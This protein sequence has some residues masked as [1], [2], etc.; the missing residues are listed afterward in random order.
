MKSKLVIGVT[1]LFLSGILLG[2]LA[3]YFW[4]E[5]KPLWILPGVLILPVAL[6]F[7]L[8]SKLVK[9]YLQ[10]LSGM[11]LLN[12]QDF[13]TRLRPVKNK[14]AREMATVFNRMMANLR[15]ERLSVREKNRFLDLL[16]E[17]SPQGIIILDSNERIADI[18]AA[19]LR[20]LQIPDV[21]GV[22]GQRIGNT[23]LE[24]ADALASMEKGVE[25]IVRPSGGYS[26]R[27]TRSSFTDQGFE[28]PFILIEE[29]TRELL[30]IEKESYE[31]IIRMMSHEVN[32][33]VGAIGSTLHVVSD[34]INAGEQDAWEDVLP[35]VDASSDRCK[36]LA[37]F[38]SNLAHV[39]KIPQPAFAYISL[40][41]Q[42][43]AVD[44]LTR[45]EC[46][47][48]DIKLTLQLSPEDRQVY[49]DGIQFEQVL[50]NV[51]KNAYESIGQGG[52]I[53]IQT[54]VSPLS[55]TIQ[56]DG[57]GITDEITEKL[58]TPFFTTKPSGQGIGLMFVREVLVNHHCRFNLYT[59]GGWTRFEIY[60]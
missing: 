47:R 56:D 4:Y 29:L 60:L 25:L 55:I 24:L 9:P 38:I 34:I 7:F 48:R 46:Q 50:V 53:R 19:G 17:A 43:R 30:K 22:K 57:P 12:E 37:Q 13:S 33:S 32:N 1:L 16:I 21:E 59:A 2:G 26:Y 40:N 39:V 49:V 52:E 45:M 58:F 8:Y 10:I 28:H 14:E 6:Y 31:R 11:R 41:E 15:N 36:H 54:S 3:V 23:G 44:A 20:F 35:A 42:A 5:S 27:C 51:I 18:N